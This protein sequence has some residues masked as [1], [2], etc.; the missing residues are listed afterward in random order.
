MSSG[1][2]WDPDFWDPDFWDPNFWISGATRRTPPVHRPSGGYAFYDDE[3][4]YYFQ[5]LFEEDEIPMLLVAIV[6]SG[7][8]D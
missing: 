8:L 7:M 5:T 4:K 3:A 2:F 6:Q 1:P